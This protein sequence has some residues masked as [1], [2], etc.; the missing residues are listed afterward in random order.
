MRGAP[1]NVDAERIVL[2]SMMLSADAIPPVL[3]SLRAED[4]YAA[5]NARVF[6]AILELYGRGEPV[7]AVS[8][9]QELRKGK[10]TTDPLDIAAMTSEVLTPASVGRYIRIVSEQATLR[11]LMRAGQDV[12]NLAVE[13]Q[14]EV[15]ELVDKAEGLVYGAS[16]RE[17]RANTVELG[18][19]V[20]T[21]LDQLEQIQQAGGRLTGLATG[22]VDLDDRLGGLQPGNLVL[23]AAR[24]GLGK[25]ALAANIARNVSVD[26]GKRVAFFSL[27]MTHREISQ[28]LLCAEAGV[29]WKKARDGKLGLE[30]WQLLNWAA[31][32]LHKAPLTIIDSGAV[33]ILDIRARARRIRAQS[34]LGLIVVDY[35]QLMSH[36]RDVDS[37][38][39]EVAEISRGLKL[40]AKELDVPVLALSQLNRE[41]EHRGDRRPR[42]PDLRESGALEQ[43]A[44][45]VLFL[46]RPN[47]GQDKLE[48]VELIVAKQRNGPTGDLHLLWEAATTKFRN[49]ALSEHRAS[50]SASP[51]GPTG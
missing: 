43:D 23:L 39:F 13:G 48:E 35:L 8:V 19:S 18:A 28:R 45:V 22:F 41:S 17:E 25:S 37:R 50:T 26:G 33:T 34:E 6:R 27:E 20:A 49:L 4:F 24:P 16:R 11:R 1:S 2:G 9:V 36:Y 51:S 47:A 14:G 38:Q 42:L 32:R 40:L 15:D 30:Q 44:D 21:T 31:E 10:E 12:V 29:P 7:E 3:E 46:H 5:V